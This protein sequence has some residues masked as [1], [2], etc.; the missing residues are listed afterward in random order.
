MDI[1]TTMRYY[2]TPSRMITVKNQKTSAGENAEMLEPFRTV[3]R[4]VK[5]YSQVYCGRS[6]VVPQKLNMELPYNPVISIL[7]IYPKELEAGSQRS[8]STSVHSSF[9]H[10]S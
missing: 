1:K 4:N 9:I 8:V 7:S 5:W 3:G 2:L 10:S 6:M